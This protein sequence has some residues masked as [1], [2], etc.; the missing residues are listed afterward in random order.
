MSLLHPATALSRTRVTGQQVLRRAQACSSTRLGKK[1]A[2][3][4]SEDGVDDSL[5]ACTSW[6]RKNR[7]RRKLKIEKVIRGGKVEDDSEGGQEEDSEGGQGED[8]EGDGERDESLPSDD[9]TPT[10]GDE[11]KSSSPVSINIHVQNTH[12]R[13]LLLAI[14]NSIKAT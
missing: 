8:S 5:L 9:E 1:L 2:S 4:L 13:S 6:R 11:E 14:C 12:A 10:K 3:W 7:K